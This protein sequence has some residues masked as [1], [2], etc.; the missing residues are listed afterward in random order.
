[1]AANDEDW[2]YDAAMHLMGEEPLFRHQSVAREL[3]II[4][5]EEGGGEVGGA[6]GAAVGAWAW[7]WGAIPGAVVG[8][9]IGDY[10]GGWIAASR[11]DAATELTD[12]QLRTM[13]KPGPGP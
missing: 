11:F 10:A 1:M 6:A 5:G 4:A 2:A 8:G 7:G 13:F 3:A 9:L 12:E